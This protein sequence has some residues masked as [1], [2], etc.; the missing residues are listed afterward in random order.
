MELVKVGIFK[1]STPINFSRKTEKMIKRRPIKAEVM[2]SLPFLTASG[3]PAE[4]I[5]EKAPKIINIKAKPAAMEIPRVRRRLV[6]SPGSVGKQP[7]A[8]SIPSPPVDG[9]QVGSGSVV[10]LPPVPTTLPLLSTQMLLRPWEP[11]IKQ[12]LP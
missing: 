12:V 6:K 5:R 10:L 2:I 4:V 3:L 11:P 8:V 9:V 1:I 7:M